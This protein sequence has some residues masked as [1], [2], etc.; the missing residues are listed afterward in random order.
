MTKKILKI[1]TISTLLLGGLSFGDELIPDT[2]GN[3]IDRAGKQRMLSQRMVKD[4]FY[5]AKGVN[6]LNALKQMKKS[7]VHFKR[8]QR[9]LNDMITNAEIKN[10]IAFVDMNL[11]EFATLSKEEYSI[12]NGTIMLDLSESILEGSDYVV[13]ALTKGQKSNEIINIAGK[14]RMLSQRIAKYYIA[15]QVGIKD[16]NTIAQ[17]KA[18]VKEFDDNL[19][20]LL[21]LKENTS[22]ITTALK[23]VAHKWGIVYKFYLNIE[24]GGLPKIVFSTTDKI[25]QKMDDIV[26]MYVPLLKD[27]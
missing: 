3:I 25:T 6:E 1:V 27:K 14:Q 23:D 8:T 20:Y 24:K 13:K 10:L 22:E 11:K 21:K 15:Y 18:S 19:K 4:Y 2:K 5:I 9:K 26:G 12:D 7:L 16:D 17:M